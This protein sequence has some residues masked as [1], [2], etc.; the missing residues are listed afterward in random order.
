MVRRG[1]DLYEFVRT[2][3]RKRMDYK[4]LRQFAR[5]SMVTGITIQSTDDV[6]SGKGIASN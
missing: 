1:L 5:M 4:R 3:R 6:N 2:E